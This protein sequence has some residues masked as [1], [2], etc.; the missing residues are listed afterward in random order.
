M[1]GNRVVKALGSGTNRRLVALLLV[2]AML[3]NCGGDDTPATA[4]PSPA[5]VASPTA[6]SSGGPA[7]DTLRLFVW[8]APTIVNPHLSVGSKDQIV[9]RM[10]YEPLASFDA[11]GKMVLFLAAKEPTVENGLLAAD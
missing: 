10:V 6:A 8:Q 2:A 7:T 9:S 4:T 1:K 3:A 11:T 5:A